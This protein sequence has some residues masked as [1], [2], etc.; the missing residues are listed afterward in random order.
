MKASEASCS[1]SRASAVQRYGST[2]TVFPISLTSL[3]KGSLRSSRSVVF[4]YFRISISALVPGLYL[5]LFAPEDPL[6]LVPGAELGPPCAFEKT[7][8]T[9]RVRSGRPESSVRDNKR[10]SQP[11]PLHFSSA[12]RVFRGFPHYLFD[13][14][15]RSRHG[16]LSGPAL[17]KLRSLE[18]DSYKS[19]GFAC[20]VAE[21]CTQMHS[22]HLR[23]SFLRGRGGDAKEPQRCPNPPA[24]RNLP[25]V[26]RHRREQPLHRRLVM[27]FA[28]SP[29][30]QGPPRSPP[31]SPRASTRDFYSLESSPLERISRER[32]SRFLGDGKFRDRYGTRM[33]AGFPGHHQ[34]ETSGRGTAR[35][36]AWEPKGAR[37]PEG[38]RSRVK[39]RPLNRS[40]STLQAPR[41]ARDEP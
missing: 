20:G 13:V 7:E 19:H 18:R 28:P 32:N 41:L 9:S 39:S 36:A 40:A 1:A 29:P 2:E 24:R 14:S 16:P 17:A 3:A 26:S 38:V 23:R 30:R 8:Q 12:S 22:T 27:C 11:S 25:P 10:R 5:L 21:E 35:R 15:L 31:S 37:G 4:W 6:A 34:D 33:I